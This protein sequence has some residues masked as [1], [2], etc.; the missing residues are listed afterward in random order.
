M[1]NIEDLRTEQSTEAVR[2]NIGGDTSIPKKHTF[3]PGPSM[4]ASAPKQRVAVDLTKDVPQEKL[5]PEIHESIVKDITVPGGMLD[6]YIDEKTKEYTERMAT[7]DQEKEMYEEEKMASEDEGEDVKFGTDSVAS[8]VIPMEREVERTTTIGNETVRQAVEIK[9]TVVEEVEV[10]DR[11]VEAED[12]PVNIDLNITNVATETHVEDEDETEVVKEVDDDEV[13]AKLKR[14]ATEKLKPVS[15]TMNIS[16]FTILKKPTAN[17][18]SVVNDQVKAAKW[19]LPSQEAIV[20]MKEFLG[21]ELENLREFSED[22]NSVAQLWRKFRCVYDHIV[23]PK[24]ATYEQWLKST[25]Y[26]DVDHYFF[27]IFIANFKGSNYLPMD[28]EDTACAETFLSDDVDIM[29]MVKF[30][31]TKAKEDFKQIYESEVTTGTGLYCSEI[32]PLSSKVAIGFKDASIYSLLE[33]EALTDKDKQK[34]SAIIELLPYIDALYIIDQANSALIPVGYKIYPENANKTTK[35]KI[36]TFNKV[37]SSLSA[38][39]FGQIRTYIRAIVDKKVGISY[40]IPSITCPKC[41]KAT[42]ERPTS[43]EALNF[44]R[45]QLSALVNSPLKS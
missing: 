29:K 45:Y 17:L 34:Y 40:I 10:K 41:G 31:N 26:R 9:E 25:P 13:L 19:V 5:P 35:S 21:T 11:A 15:N 4:D 8:N 44:T 43:A 42:T 1:S 6:K 14:L 3:V 30:E 7:F 23:S 22:A 24:P 39:E 32:V 16:S 37:L 18:S 28:C 12:E 33:I 36:M 27:A 20:L 2:V 38:D